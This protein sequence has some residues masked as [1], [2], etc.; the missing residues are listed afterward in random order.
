MISDIVKIHSNF[1][2]VKT[3]DNILECKIREKLKKEKLEIF[4]GDSVLLD[5]INPESNQAVIIEILERKNFILRPSIANIDQIIVIA[6]LD[7]PA[8]NFTQLN[9]YLIHSKLYNIPVILCINKSDIPEK[10]DFK[11]QIVS[12]Y[13]SLGYK[14]IFTSTKTGIGIEEFKNALMSKRSV[15]CGMS[16]VGKSSLLNKI[17]PDLNLKIGEISVKTL[18]GTHTTRHVELID[19]P[20]ET[21]NLTQVADTPGFSHLKFDNVLPEIISQSFKEISELSK[22][23]YYANCL[24]I[25]ENNCNVLTNIDKIAVSRYESY[26][27][28]INEAMKYKEKLLNSRHKIEENFKTKDMRNKNKI[29]IVKL[30][31]QQREISRKTA[32]Q[33]INLV[34][35]YDASRLE[36]EK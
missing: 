31:I 11:E 16:G 32:K 10:D 12:I 13:E 1:Y 18:M 7:Q 33:K 17:Y 4:V 24:H 35:I 3:G 20:L 22:N 19:I 6:S 30:G 25:E 21:D 28:F 26:K 14:I 34:S 27:I 29:K 36:D 15:L 23:C 8:L 5:E 9:R 2:Y